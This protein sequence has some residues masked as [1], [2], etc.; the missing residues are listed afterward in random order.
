ML[1]RIVSSHGAETHPRTVKVSVTTIT[2][3]PIQDVRNNNFFVPT[4]TLRD[5]RQYHGVR[6]SYMLLACMQQHFSVLNPCAPPRSHCTF[7]VQRLKQIFSY[8]ASY[9][10]YQSD[11]LNAS[12]SSDV[13]HYSYWKWTY[14]T[15]WRV[16][17]CS[18]T[19][20]ERV[21]RLI[22]LLHVHLSWMECCD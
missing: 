20:I 4:P 9:T 3:A 14:P 10:A 18:L 19:V 13:G 12:H 8:M 11:N 22:C 17:V 15:K 21:L 7:I 1:P 6:Y 16:D 5:A 2:C